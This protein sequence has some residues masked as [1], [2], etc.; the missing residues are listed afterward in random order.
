MDRNFCILGFRGINID[1]FEHKNIIL[2]ATVWSHVSGDNYIPMIARILAMI[3]LA[4]Y[5]PA[6][7]CAAR[8]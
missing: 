4:H 1:D 7:A 3:L 2:R 5:Y 8:G 6:R